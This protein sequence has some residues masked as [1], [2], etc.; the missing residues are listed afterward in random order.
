VDPSRQGF[1]A[2]LESIGP[3]SLYC[4]IPDF[5]VLSKTKFQN[6]VRVVG[7]IWLF[8]ELAGV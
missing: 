8:P 2:I 7:S 1:T 6:P 5:P 4:I 3:V